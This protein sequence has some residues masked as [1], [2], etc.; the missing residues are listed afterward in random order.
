MDAR[1]TAIVYCRTSTAG[2]K[3]S[4][5]IRAQVERDK[6]LIERHNVRL[7]KYGPKKDG[8]L[9]DDGVS[10]SLLEGRDFA[11]FID[12]LEAARVRPNYLIVFS[13]SRVSR[14]DKSS[15]EMS[16]LVKSAT[17][18]ARIKAVLLG[19]GVKVIDE[20]GVNDPATVM[21]DLKTTLSTEEYKLIR[22]RT[23]AGKARHLAEGKFAKGGKPPYGYRQV[24]LNGVDRKQGWTL[25]PD[26]DAAANLRR[27]LAWYVEGGVTHAARKATQAGMPT[28]MATTANRKNKAE[29]WTPCR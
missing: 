18:N 1:E 26:G 4:E 29:D 19:A 21:F 28:P 15:R 23:M 27:L 10:G 3:D 5:T 22:Q 7:L 13:L 9:I 14:L 25:Q 12:D 2:Q 11:K 8:W 17:D 20:D 24:P 6:R 16:K